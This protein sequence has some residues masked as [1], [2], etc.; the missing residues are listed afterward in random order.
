MTGIPLPSYEESEER[1]AAGA[2][3][4]VNEG[5]GRHENDAHFDDDIPI[6]VGCP[7]SDNLANDNV[8]NGN[9]TSQSNDD[10]TDAHMT[11][12]LND[13][14]VTPR[15]V[16][17]FHNPTYADLNASNSSANAA[18]ANANAT[19]KKEP[20]YDEVRS[21]FPR[22]CSGQ[23]RR[24]VSSANGEPIYSEIPS[25]RPIAGSAENHVTLNGVTRDSTSVGGGNAN[26]A[27]DTS[28]ADNEMNASLEGCKL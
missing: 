24:P 23:S 21:S 12:Q 22:P 19:D 4:F 9:M 7:E 28:L 27:F 1:G 2:V 8:T 15:S 16:R 5:Y 25:K 20:L 18:H 26:M 10:I 17:G 6:T 11:S 3:G 14:Y 13:G